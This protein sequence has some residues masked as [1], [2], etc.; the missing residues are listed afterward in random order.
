MNYLLNC[1]FSLVNWAESSWELFGFE[2]VN[3][4]RENICTTQGPGMIMMPSPLPFTKSAHLCKTFDAEMGVCKTDEIQNSMNAALLNNP[5]KDVC[6]NEMY[7]FWCGLSD[8]MTEDVWLNVNNNEEIQNIGKPWHSGE[9]NGRDQENCIETR[10]SITDLINKTSWNDASCE[11]RSECFFCDFKKRP[12]YK[13][14]GLSLCQMENFD[15]KYKWTNMIIDGKYVLRGYKGSLI[16]WNETNKTWKITGNFGKKQKQITISNLREMYPVG[17]QKW[18]LAQDNCIEESIDS[19]NKVVLNLSPCDDNSFNCNDGTCISISRRCDLNIDCPDSSDEKNCTFLV[20]PTWY[21]MNVP[22][23]KS[24]DQK[25]NQIT[26]K[27]T[28]LNILDIDI[29][30]SRIETQFKMM[31][32]WYD[33][34]LSFKNLK[35]DEHNNWVT[36]EENIWIPKLRFHNTESKATTLSD[37]ESWITIKSEGNFSNSDVVSLENTRNYI[38]SENKLTQTRTYN[39]NFLCNYKLGWYPFDTQICFMNISLLKPEDQ[40]TLQLVKPDDIPFNGSHDLTE[41]NFMEA[42]V[43]NGTFEDG[44]RG[45]S[46]KIFF[47]RNIFSQI[48]TIYV[49]TTLIMVVS[50]LTTFFNNR[51]WFGHIITINLTVSDSTRPNTATHNPNHNFSGNARADDNADEYR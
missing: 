3:D 42:T 30:K 12:E 41:Y 17:L 36:N 31:I 20:K 7:F 16:F 46:V 49:P 34:R 44:M 14:R 24:Q 29:V 35:P 38:G 19:T 18:D 47:K 27:L 8:K 6:L 50:Y 2:E 26:L 39:I 22:P 28:L 1:L 23:P 37:S 43:D 9:P 11:D 48:M 5:Q 13:L 25:F 21:L 51:Q 4:F 32:S 15:Y 33:G 40:F 10:L 45:V